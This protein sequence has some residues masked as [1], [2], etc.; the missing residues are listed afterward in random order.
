MARNR[1]VINRL[2]QNHKSHDIRDYRRRNYDCVT[3]SGHHP[4][5]RA[6]VLIG[7]TRFGPITDGSVGKRA[8]R[9][10]FLRLYLS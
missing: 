5:R 2:P 7:G 3:L 1:T 10:V 6:C 8:A 4:G 9:V